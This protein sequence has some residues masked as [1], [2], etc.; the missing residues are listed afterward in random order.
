MSTPFALRQLGRIVLA[1]SSLAIAAAPASAEDHSK[2]LIGSSDLCPASVDGLSKAYGA[3]VGCHC[4]SEAAPGSVWGSGP[5]TADSDICTAARHAGVVGAGGGP[6]WARLG[7][8]EDSYIASTANG[9]TTSAYGSYG[10]A[11]DFIEAPG[12]EPLKPC[13]GSMEGQPERL[14]CRCSAEQTQSGSVWGTSLYTEDS[15]VCRAALHAGATGAEGGRVSVSVVA[16]Q[17]GYFGT[18]QNGV[19]SETY[20]PWGKSFMFGD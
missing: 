3:I 20:G 6:V 15:A 1:G 2:A 7:L 8:G 12:A 9:V 5:Y 13:P 16:G 4:P 10:V 17:P 19:S 11:F 18:D 14:A